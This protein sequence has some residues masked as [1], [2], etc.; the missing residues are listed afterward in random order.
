MKQNLK[1][2]ELRSAPK[3]MRTRKSP[4]PDGIS[5]EMLTHLGSATVN[6]FLETFNLSWQ[7]GRLPQIW[8]EATIIPVFQEGERPRHGLQLPP[9]QPDQLYGE[10][11]VENLINGRPRWY[12]ESADILTS[13]QAGFRQFRS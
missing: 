13:E 12:L 10:D 8:R 7:E 1:P 5:S 2:E 9:D 3:T 11:H 4:G 6:K